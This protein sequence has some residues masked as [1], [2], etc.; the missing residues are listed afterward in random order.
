TFEEEQEYLQYLVDEN[1]DIE[2]V[3]NKSDS[4]DD[5][6]PHSVEENEYSDI[7][8]IEK[9]KLT[10]HCISYLTKTCKCIIV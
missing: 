4:E 3:T 7:E 9:R 5:Y 10:L 2:E 8:D 1:S 6:V